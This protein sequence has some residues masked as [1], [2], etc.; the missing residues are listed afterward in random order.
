MKLTVESHSQDDT[1]VKSADLGALLGQ[2]V[3][4]ALESFTSANNIL[5]HGENYENTGDFR[6]YAKGGLFLNYGGIDK[7]AVTNAMNGL[8]TGQAINELWRTQKIFIMGGGAC[9]DNQGIGSGP[10]QYSICRNGQAWY[11][12]Y[13]Q[14]NDVI[15]VTAHQWGWVSFPPG[16]DKLGQGDFSLVT[17]PNVIS[18]SLDA[19]NVA[20]YNY[21]NVTSYQRAQSALVDGWANPGYLG[22][23]WE[24][25]F[26]IPVCDI[27][28]TITSEYFD[29][30]Y[31]LQDY[32]HDSR[33]VWCGPICKGDVQTTK[34]FIHAANMDGF[35]SP[36]HLCDDDNTPTDQQWW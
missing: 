4:G 23:A 15:S 5:M 29:K 10:Q 17:V 21:N 28:Q 11:L 33:P 22:A 18:S 26:T 3:T 6:S 12:Y 13:W 19:Y 32:D 16:A 9:G 2:F 7:V 14:E 8:I 20:G 34:D 36:R 25:T 1:F 31:I 30:A 27:S 35:E 24:G